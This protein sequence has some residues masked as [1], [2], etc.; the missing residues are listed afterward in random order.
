[1]HVQLFL[2]SSVTV[3]LHILYI[4]FSGP[5]RYVCDLPARTKERIGVI[6]S[7]CQS[8]Q[9]RFE[10]LGEMLHLTKEDIAKLRVHVQHQ[11]PVGDM[12]FRFLEQR[13]RELTVD[14]L[15]DMVRC[16]GR[17]DLA[18]DIRMWM[19]EDCSLIEGCTPD[20]GCI[21]QPSTT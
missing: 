16:L 20:S 13:Y 21:I 19:K 12:F 11:G 9:C 1:M 15:C 3:H 8:N 14:D 10:I 7:D 17:P 6:I 2:S 18:D 4:V 5:I